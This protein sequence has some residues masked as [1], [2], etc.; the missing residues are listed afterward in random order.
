[1]DGIIDAIEGISFGPVLENG[2]Q[3]LLFVS[4]DHFQIYGKQLNRFIL[5][6]IV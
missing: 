6:E 4:D 5:F 3:S 1:M 2:N